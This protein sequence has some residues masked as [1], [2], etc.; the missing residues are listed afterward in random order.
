MNFIFVSNRDVFLVKM[1]TVTL[2]FSNK[3]IGF[4]LNSSKSDLPY[5][6]ENKRLPCDQVDV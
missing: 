1:Y 5:S 2:Y 6:T 4:K 3:L